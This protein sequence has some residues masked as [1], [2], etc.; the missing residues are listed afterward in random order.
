[1]Y[2][3]NLFAI[4]N[5]VGVSR[6]VQFRIATGGPYKV[7]LDC[8]SSSYVGQELQCT[9]IL[10]DEGEVP[11]ESTSTVWVD[12]N[13]NGVADAGE[14][15]SSF[16][17]QTVPLQNITQLVSINVPSSHATGL[18]IVRVDTSYANSA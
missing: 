13:N 11:T 6:L 2:T 14:P 3:A 12:T 5:N 9:V 17:K 10:Q 8:P 16:S 7:Y 4:Y 1:M 15:Q 18:H